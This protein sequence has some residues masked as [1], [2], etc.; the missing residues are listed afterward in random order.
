MRP[1]LAT[2]VLASSLLFAAGQSVQFRPDVILFNGKIVTIDPAF[3]YAQ[4]VAIAGGRFVAVGSD[5]DVRPLAAPQTRLVDLRGRTVIPGLADNHLHSAGGGPGV[6]LSGARTIGELLDAIAARARLVGPAQLVLTNSD[7]HEGQLKEQR[8]PLRR[9]LDAAAPRHPVVVVRGGHEY[10][11]N[12]AALDRWNITKQTP[13][14][15]GGRIGRDDDGELNGELVDRAMDLVKLPPRPSRTPE[16]RVSDQVAEYEKLHAAGLTTVRHPGGSIEQY[17][18]LQDIKRRGLL[19]MRVVFLLRPDTQQGP[20]GVRAALEEWGVRFDSGDAGLRVGG[21]KLNVDG[22]FEG[23]W[24]REP[25]AEPWGEHG[26]YRGIN[27]LP[28]DRFTAIVRELNRLGWRVWTHAVGDAA[29]DEVLAGYEAADAD[30]PISGRR[31]GIEHAFQAR[32]DHF[33]RMQRLGLGISAQNHLYLAGPSLAKYWGPSRA[34]WTTPM[35][36]FLDANLPT[37]AGTDSPVVPYHPLRAI[38]HFVTRRTMSGAEMGAD[39]QITRE[40]ALRASTVGGAW[41]SFEEDA[42][43]SIEPGK[44]ADLVVL[45]GDLMTCPEDEIARLTVLMTMV[46]GKAVFEHPDFGVGVLQTGSI[47]LENEY[48]RATRNGAPCAEPATGCGD[49]IV[50]A[51]GPVEL[52]AHGRA[53]KMI[54]GDIAVFPAAERYVSPIGGEFLEVHIKSGHPPVQSPQALVPPQKNTILFEGPSFV[55]FEEKLDP[56]DTRARHS[57]SQRVVIVLNAT[58][59]QQWPDGQPEI[60][61]DQIPDEV[62]FNPPVIHVV[63]TVG[64][65]PLRNIVIEF[66]PTSR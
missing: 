33:P 15:P 18:L 52:L 24:M 28:G 21:V 61:R 19:S 30:N 62:R 48:V 14:P 22:G 46:G 47:V 60:F 37:S 1:I 45:S 38:Y 6:D 7:W 58:R 12:S 3:T 20:A 16:E 26:Q 50:V 10:I 32:P 4:A 53:R 51:L 44:Y 2:P 31:W 23:G 11:L 25:Y 65:R 56:G 27:T 29:I 54:R 36:A 8:L 40:Q 57:H 39:Q 55:V 64:D 63:K 17:R 9:D 13:E 59:L 34:A 66:R 49:R 5:V 35:R 41:L 43:G 42:K